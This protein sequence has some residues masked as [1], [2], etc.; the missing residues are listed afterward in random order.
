MTPLLAYRSAEQQSHMGH[1]SGGVGECW[2]LVQLLAASD[3]PEHIRLPEPA[4]IVVD[5]Q[6]DF[7][8]PGAPLE[9]ADARSTIPVIA[10]L[11][12]QFRGR[13]RPV[14]FTRFLARETRDLMWLWSPQCW[15]DTRCC[16]LPLS[17]SSIWS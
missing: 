5:M 1:R 2:T 9:V 6:N 10:I 4:L 17:F 11:V 16:D 13:G 8:L 12:D 15:P 7:V 14:I 3:T